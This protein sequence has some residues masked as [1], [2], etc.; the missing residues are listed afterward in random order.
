MFKVYKIDN[1]KEVL[2]GMFPSGYEAGRY[3]ANAAFTHKLVYLNYEK[4]D[5]PED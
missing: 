2:L 4:N 3:A 1:G 5:L